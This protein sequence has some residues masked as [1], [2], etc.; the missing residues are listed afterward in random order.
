MKLIIIFAVSFLTSCVEDTLRDEVK[1]CVYYKNV[2]VKDAIILTWQG[3]EKG[4]T[5]ETSTDS[6]GY[7]Y[8]KKSVDTI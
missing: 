6:L 7:F 8:L 5:K 1:A 2:P 3:Y 4:F